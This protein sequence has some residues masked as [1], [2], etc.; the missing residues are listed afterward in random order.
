MNFLLLSTVTSYP[1]YLI[2][3]GI[4]HVIS[5][6]P[7]D[8]SL[9]FFLSSSLN[10]KNSLESEAKWHKDIIIPGETLLPPNTHTDIVFLNEAN[11]ISFEANIYMRTYTHL[12]REANLLLKCDYLKRQP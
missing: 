4:Y 5:L 3:L 2:K 6:F 7:E 11:V 1:N 9:F 8:R 10:N 12:V